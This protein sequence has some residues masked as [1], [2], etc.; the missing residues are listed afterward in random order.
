MAE[1]RTHVHN[2]GDEILVLEAK[3]RDKRREL[4]EESDLKF[5]MAHPEGRRF[6]LKLLSDGGLF[7]TSFTGNANTYFNEGRRD[8]A[9][10]LL[11]SITSSCP[12]QY[13]LAQQEHLKK[14]MD[15]E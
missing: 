9:L 14:E 12:D 1:R 6:V 10:Q 11:G 3:K 8:M 7:K 4:T 5:V 13:L 2:A 15:N